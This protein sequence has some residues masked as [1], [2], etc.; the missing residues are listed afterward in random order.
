M[1]HQDRVPP[2]AWGFII[3]IL[4]PFALALLSGCATYESQLIAYEKCGPE[5]TVDWDDNPSDPPP[6]CNR[7]GWNGHSYEVHHDNR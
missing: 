4:L 2:I 5:G 1:T 6:H 3:G 7:T